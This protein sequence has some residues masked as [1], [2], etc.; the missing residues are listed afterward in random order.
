MG[1][2]HSSG[3]IQEALVIICITAT[4]I[5]SSQRPDLMDEKIK[6]KTCRTSVGI[7]TRAYLNQE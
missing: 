6:I 3:G 1:A 4:Q 5:I 2:K 7:E